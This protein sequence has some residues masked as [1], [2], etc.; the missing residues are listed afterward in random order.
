[1]ATIARNAPLTIRAAKAALSRLRRDRRRDGGEIADLVADCYASDDFREGVSA[2][3]AKR[4]P[5]SPAADAAATGS[6][7]GDS[8]RHGRGD[9]AAA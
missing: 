9:A 4:P 8:E 5:N 6:R 3:L 7:R 1:M 2:F